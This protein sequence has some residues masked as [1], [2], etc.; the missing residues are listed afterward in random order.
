[1]NNSFVL[2]YQCTLLLPDG[3]QNT[4]NFK[5][6]ESNLL[7]ADGKTFSLANINLNWLQDKLVVWHD[8]RRLAV[9]GSR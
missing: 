5:Y 7:F 4:G 2:F 1:M 8:E 3:S 9:L 6:R